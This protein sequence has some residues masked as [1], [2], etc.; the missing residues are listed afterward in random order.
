MMLLMTMTTILGLWPLLNEGSAQAE[1]LK[2][3]VITLVYGLGFGMGLVLLVVPA[4]VAAQRD[5]ARPLI[6]ARR[7]LAAQAPVRW[8]VM[9]AAG[10]C[11]AWLAG[12]VGWVVVRGGVHPV[13]LDL[14]PALQGM[15]ASRAGLLL[16]VVG[17]LAI[18]ILVYLVAALAYGRL[19]KS[20]VS[21]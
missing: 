15:E 2:P 21:G 4:L 20:K 11:L 12:T 19:A 5:M 6:A 1:F 17:A 3:T 7:A 10:L 18:L 9:G 14:L 8:F 16:F 13:L